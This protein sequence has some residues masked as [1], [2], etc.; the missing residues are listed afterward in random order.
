M[1]SQATVVPLGRLGRA[2]DQLGSSQTTGTAQE[3]LVSFQ[4]KVN[5]LEQLRQIC[6]VFDSNHIEN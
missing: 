3:R 2:Q 4:G 5:P 1:R 6:L